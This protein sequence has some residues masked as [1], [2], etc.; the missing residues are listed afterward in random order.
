[1]KKIIPFIALLVIFSSCGKKQPEVS[2]GKIDLNIVDQY[3]RNYALSIDSTGQTEA[4]VTERDTPTRSYS[5]AMNQQMFDSISNVAGRV[6]AEKLDTA[7]AD[8]CKVC[9]SYNI[10]FHNK[11]NVVTTKVKNIKSDST[12]VKLD[13]LVELLYK[14]IRTADKDVSIV[15]KKEK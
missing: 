15:T 5:F 6:E 1:M 3:K 2:F 14:V 7:Y 8:S 4:S 9:I 13:N 12:L 11:G 10:A